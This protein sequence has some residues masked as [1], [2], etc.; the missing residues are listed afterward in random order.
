MASIEPLSPA[1]EE[2]WRA[3]M[4]IML[5]LRRRLDSELERAAGINTNEYAVLASL[6]EAGSHRLRMTDVARATD[7]SASR[8]TRVVDELDSRGLAS[9]KASTEDGRGNV[10]GLTWAGLAKVKAARP[11]HIFSVR[12][13]VLDHLEPATTHEAARALARVAARLGG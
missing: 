7:L 1:E 11:V 4:R 10:A 8:V 2:F 12:A 3:L 9:K 6:F 5:S 13:L